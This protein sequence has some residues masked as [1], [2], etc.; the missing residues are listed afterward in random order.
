MLLGF[1]LL[2]SAKFPFC[3]QSSGVSAWAAGR[4]WSGLIGN[5]GLLVGAGGVRRPLFRF[6]PMSGGVATFVG[7]S[8]IGPRWLTGRPVSGPRGFRT[9]RS[10]GRDLRGGRLIGGRVPDLPL[11]YG[12]PVSGSSVGASFW[13]VWRPFRGDSTRHRRV[14]LWSVVPEFEDC[15]RRVAGRWRGVV[16]RGLGFPALVALDVSSIAVASGARNVRAGS[17]VNTMAGGRSGAVASSG[18]AWWG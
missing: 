2:G 13:C 8:S 6:S 5:F 10:P 17:A 11:F 9:R 4:A 12:F 15:Q 3:P 14:A 7:A 18:S 16:W 1:P